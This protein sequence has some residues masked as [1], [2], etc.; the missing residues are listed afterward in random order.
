MMPVRPERGV[1]R[2]LAAL[3]RDSRTWLDTGIVTDVQPDRRWG[4][5]LFLTLADGRPVEARPAWLHADG[6]RGE[7]DEI[8]KGAEFLVFFPGGDVNA[9]IAFGSPASSEQ[10]PGEGWDGTHEINGV[11][12]YVREQ[13]DTVEGVLRRE[14]LDDLSTHLGDVS[15]LAQALATAGAA[16]TAAATMP[17]VTLANVA[18]LA[19]AT[20]N[21]LGG[22][23]TAAA[24]LK[25][26]TDAMKVRVDAAKAGEGGA[27]FVS[28]F[29]KVRDS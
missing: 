3:T 7:F 29:L 27:P 24:A 22:V 1:G 11:P 8:A 14:L 23:T 9:G 26:S 4:R 6:G 20:A 2:M 13:G 12:L 28:T 25:A 16:A 19:V 17:T 18:A 21:A 10:G 5:R 15:A